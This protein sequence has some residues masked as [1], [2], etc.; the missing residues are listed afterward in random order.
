MAA[1]VEMIDVTCESDGYTILNS[2]SHEFSE[3]R[4][5]VIMGT[6][7]SGK[8]VLLKVA[9][10]LRIPESGS[11][12]MFGKEIA[13]TNDKEILQLRRRNG[14]VF[15]DAALWA[16]LTVYQN[17]ALPLQFHN[18][19]MSDDEISKKIMPSVKEFG[20]E[21]NLQL[22]PAMLSTGERK[23]ASFL[24][25]LMLDPD[26]LF[27]DDPT[28][29]VDSSAANLMLQALKNLK[30]RGK[31]LIMTTHNA[32]FTSQLADDLVIVKAGQVIE[33]GDFHSVTRS[34]NRD[35]ANVLS[36]V[37]SQA[38]TFDDDILNLLGDEGSPE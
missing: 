13:K 20:I 38:A 22:R 32:T 31:T 30:A 17:L 6:S 4:C 37:L 19:G 16:N 1:A 21:S 2:I 24:R 18:P 35:V 9:A 14:F 23:I 15:Q 27:I 25:G 29:S 3:G 28:T 10:G 7:G 11:V 8:S 26:L 33:S 34:T 12:L 36:E 5:A